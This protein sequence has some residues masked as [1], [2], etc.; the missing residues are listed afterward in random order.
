VFAF[1]LDQARVMKEKRCLGR[2]RCPLTHE[3]LAG[4]GCLLQPGRNGDSIPGHQEIAARE[5]VGCHD[6]ARVYPHAQQ[7]APA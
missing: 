2:G 1:H 5:V 3:N 4:I 6:L 7:Q